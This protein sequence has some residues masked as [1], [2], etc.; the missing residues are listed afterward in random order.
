MTS[1]TIGSSIP[2]QS[3]LDRTVPSQWQPQLRADLNEL[4]AFRAAQQPAPD[5]DK[6]EAM[7]AR[8]KHAGA[9][10]AMRLEAAMMNL[11]HDHR[12]QLEKWIGSRRS[13]AEWAV[14]QIAG[15]YVPGWRHIDDYLKTL[16]L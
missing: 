1:T 12:P 14:K 13:R 4:Q 11:L 6:A 7:K 15:E 8:A 5:P 9:Y 16:S 10:K 3:A 2:Y